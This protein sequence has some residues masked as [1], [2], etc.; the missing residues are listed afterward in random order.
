MLVDHG[1]EDKV[2][3]AQH[4]FTAVSYHVSQI[5]TF[6]GDNASSND[7]QTKHLGGL[8]N[9]FD[10]VNHVRCFN[11]TMQLSAWAL[12]KPFSAVHNHR[13]SNSGSIEDDEAVKTPPSVESDDDHE[14]NSD[15]EDNGAATDIDGDDDDND[16]DKDEDDDNDDDKD[17]SLQ[18]LDDEAR[19]KLLSV[20]HLTR[21][22][23]N[24]DCAG[25]P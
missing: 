4:S 12:L 15:I 21:Y 3:N 6:T 2:C 5:L 18:E 7:K 1:L 10:T 14:D 11:H 13:D 20:Q 22:A 24:S 8:P 25:L 9:T 19:E 16:D 17:D 23:T